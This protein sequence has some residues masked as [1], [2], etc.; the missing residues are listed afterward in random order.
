MVAIAASTGAKACE[1]PLPFGA[2]TTI[3]WRD[4]E[5]GLPQIQALKAGRKTLK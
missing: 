2:M 1:G 3:E 5:R 4:R